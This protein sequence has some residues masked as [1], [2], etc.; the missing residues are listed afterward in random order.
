MKYTLLL[1]VLSLFA[2]MSSAQTV[3]KLYNGVIP[4][5]VAGPDKES[6]KEGRVEISNVTRPTLEVFLPLKGKA[7]GTAVV[8][9]QAA[10][11]QLT[12]IIMKECLLR[13]NS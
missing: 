2:G 4:N 6:S 13:G 12:P 1:L 5:E 9:A 11:M 8:I 10:A 7:N 3:L